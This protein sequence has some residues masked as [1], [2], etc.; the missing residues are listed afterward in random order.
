MENASKALLIAGGMLIALLVIGALLLM[1]NQIGDYEKA[2]TTSDKVS[3]IVDF[4]KEFEKYTYDNNIKV[5]DLISLI[6]KAV[7]YNKKDAVNNSVDY[8]KKITITVTNI[9]A[10]KTKYGVN[11]KSNIF[12][13]NNTDKIDV[14]DRNNDISKAIEK[15]SELEKNYTLGVMSNL[16]AN[17]DN[18]KNGD[19]TI[20]DVAGKDINGMNLA[21]IEQYREYSEFKSSTFESTGTNYDGKQIIGL[22]FKFIK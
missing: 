1:F 2:Q 21:T 5:Y 14:K 20:K 12:T 10:F 3:Q 18:I 17:Y 13:A 9:K 22:S 16:S 6:N 8:N 19:K 15:F 4:N 11:G 7:D